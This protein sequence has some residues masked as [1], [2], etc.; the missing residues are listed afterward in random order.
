MTYIIY[1]YILVSI[2]IYTTYYTYQTTSSGHVLVVLHHWTIHCFYTICIHNVAVKNLTGSQYLFILIISFVKTTL[3]LTIPTLRPLHFNLKTYIFYI[4]T[5][6]LAAS[7]IV[8]HAELITV[9]NILKKY[10]ST[11]E[12]SIN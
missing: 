7:V 11:S 5:I 1:K 10:L 3:F 4:L 8:S 2:I 6:I 12:Y 9:D